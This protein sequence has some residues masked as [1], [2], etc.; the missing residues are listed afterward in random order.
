[1]GNLNVYEFHQK[2]I[3]WEMDWSETKPDGTR[4]YPDMPEKE[5]VFEPEMALAWLL[6]KNVVIINSH[7]WKKGKWPQE[8]CDS[9]S[10]SVDCSDVFSWASADAEPLFYDDLED[11]YDHY[12]KDSY[13]GPAIW[14][15]KRRKQL[16]QKPV[17]DRIQQAGIWNLEEISKD[18]EN[19][20]TIHNN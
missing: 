4:I 15:I 9:F 16:P 1:M 19:D 18:W 3:R 11:L 5:M 12:A 7:W 2:T 17:Y 14:C 8:A 10:I 6:V 20:E 13:W